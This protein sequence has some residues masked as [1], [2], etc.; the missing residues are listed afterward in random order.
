[1]ILRVGRYI[2][3]IDI[4]AQLSPEN[5]LYSHSTMYSVDPYTFTGVQEIFRV[6]ERF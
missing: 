6:S 5:Y 2:S 3:P 1:M 4:E